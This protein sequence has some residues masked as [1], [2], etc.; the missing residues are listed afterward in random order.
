MKFKIAK[1][2]ATIICANIVLV[3]AEDTTTLEDINVTTVS[4]ASGYEQK[5]K[6]APASITVI[7]GEEI[8]KKSFTDLADVLKS[9]PGVI[10]QGSG[11]EQS[12]SIRGMSSSYTL[13]L[14]DGRPAQGGDT[15]EFNGG[16]KGQQLALM[17]PL[18]MIE[19]IEVVRGPASGLYGSDAMGGVINI[20]TK[21][22]MNKWSGSISTEYIKGDKSNEVNEDGYNTSFVLNGP[23]INDVLGIQISGGFR[24]TEEGNQVAFGDSTTADA[25]YTNKNIGTKL[26]WNVNDTNTITAGQSHTDTLNKRTPG[27]SLL[28]TASATRQGSVKDNYFL[29]HDGKYDRLTLKS[30]LNYDYAKNDTTRGT[31]NGVQ[32]NTLTLNSQATYMF[33]T[34]TLSGGLTH[35]KEELSDGATGL[36]YTYNP[37]G[38]ITLERYQ[39][40]AFL[41]DEWMLTDDLSLT[42]SGRY[43]NNEQFGD[44]IS[45]KAYLVYHLTDNLSLKGGAIA[46]YKAPSLRNSAPEF[47]PSSMGG[48]SLP[49]SELTP[50]TSLTYEI[51]VDY[52]ND[53]LGLKSSFTVYQTDFKDRITRGDI[54]CAV[55]IDCTYNGVVYPAGTSTYRETVNVDEAEVK[56]VEVTFDYELTENLNSRSNYT[57]TDSEQ[58]TGSS[59]GQPLNDLPEHVFNSGLIYD[60][61]KTTN[62]WTQ[63]SY[64]AE[65]VSDTT[66][67]ESYTLID[68]GLVHKA[69]KDVTL[70]VG[71]YNLTNREVANSVNGYVDGRR[72]SLGMNYKF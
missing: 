12:I 67:S 14:I 53:P 57:F 40:S 46:G 42:L 54:I 71:T 59:A 69:T 32:F 28:S 44:H 2:V 55:G 17:P 18:E 21:K 61:N 49:N 15:F 8:A 62:L 27:E 47:I 36:I 37:T 5:L 3:E 51:G 6:D 41:E 63:L 48:Y 25:D 58:K 1:S 11:T 70:K 33:D 26:T 52:E 13:F 72:Y 29:T 19:R 31:G 60:F 24:R 10:V 65:G 23:I 16:G 34:H 35:K 50:E 38:Y 9:V 39:N 20:I 68:L 7:S 66:T 45:P 56:G 64:T 22:S 30:Y 4:T 43:D